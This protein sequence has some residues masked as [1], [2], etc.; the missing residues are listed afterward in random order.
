[1]APHSQVFKVGC[2]LFV[3]AVLALAE[4]RPGLASEP[5]AKTD[6]KELAK[7]PPYKR[8]LQGEDAKRVAELEA[9]VNKLDEAGRFTE[10]AEVAKVNHMENSSKR[11]ALS[12]GHNLSNLG[13][14]GATLSHGLLVI[15]RCYANKWSSSNET[16]RTN[17]YRAQPPHGS[18]KSSFWGFFLSSWCC[19]RCRSQDFSTC[20]CESSTVNVIVGGT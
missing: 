9:K 13:T 10:A 5:P 17:R 12:Q 3:S 19:L 15:S 20:A 7:I 4:N 18:I 11:S 6:P 16:A 1:M 8:L 14:F 2:L